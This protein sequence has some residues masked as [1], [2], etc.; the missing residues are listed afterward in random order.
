[1]PMFVGKNQRC[2]V[3]AVDMKPELMASADFGDRRHV[4]DDPGTGRPGGRDHSERFAPAAKVGFDGGFES[5]RIHLELLIDRDPPQRLTSDT[6]QSGGLVERVMRFRRRIRYRLRA[7]GRDS[8][9]D[10][11]WELPRERQRETA[12]VCF[13][14]SAGERSVESIGPSYAFADP[15]QRPVLLRQSPCR[16]AW[17]SSGRSSSPRAR[18]SPGP[19]SRDKWC[20]ALASDRRLLPARDGGADRR[21]TA[22]RDGWAGK[23]KKRRCDRS[24]CIRVCDAGWSRDRKTT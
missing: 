18:E 19:P 12:E 8:V 10:C 20:R 22:A 1:M 4:V 11:V 24:V 21:Y 14:A 9:L 3:R 7:D 6:E 15:V 16:S 13:V 5:V 17:D 2:A 23:S